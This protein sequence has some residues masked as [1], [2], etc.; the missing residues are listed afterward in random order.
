M[1]IGDKDKKT[2]V[3]KIV[4]QENVVGAEALFENWEKKRHPFLCRACRIEKGGYI[5][6]DFGREICG[7]VH[8]LFGWND[9]RGGVRIRL[10]ESV[11]ETCA[12][13]GEKNA[14][15]H[16]SL[17][18]AVYPVV[19][20]GD[21]STSESGFRFARIDGAKEEAVHV[22]MIFVEEEK[23]GLTPKGRFICSDERLNEI[24]KVAE[25]TISL[26]V[27]SD[28][29][30]DGIKRDRVFW[31]G[32]FYPELLGASAIYGQIPQFRKALDMV[33]EFQGSWINNIP[34]YSAW[35]LICLEKYYELSADDAYVIEM[36]PYI[37]KV[38]KDFSIIVGERGDVSYDKSELSYY[39]GNE[40]FIDW[41]TYST[42][43]SEIGWK[44]L[45]IYA[46]KQT[47]ILLTRFGLS[48]ARADELLKRLDN[49]EYKASKFKQ[50]TAL[51][52]LAGKIGEKEARS[53][54]ECDGAA[55]M[56]AF[57]SFAIAE[58]LRKIGDGEFVLQILKEYFGA[59][60][61]LGATTFW[62]D[63]DLKWL[64]DN[65]LPLDA[66]PEEGRKSIHADFGR[67]CYTGLR[68][69]LCHG[70]SSGF[71]DFFYRHILGIMAVE[72]GY[73]KIKIEPHLCGMDYAEGEI[74][75]LYG[76]IYI[77]H[78]VVN[79]K[80]ESTVRLPEGITREE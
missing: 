60:L 70:W 38:I 42:E 33:K 54:L 16:H 10:G 50:V 58:A 77:R 41:P 31:M 44:Y 65:P 20:C 43:D 1:N 21:V 69:S 39:V 72:P 25:H 22:S 71:I 34:S 26:C 37:E 64:E 15:N 24:Y 73:K 66:M 14:G 13:M 59:M 78:E 47:K 80:V 51:G 62:E 55:G 5:I 11:V 40:F 19:S 75:S 4:K 12:E 29:V 9:I 56:T 49:Q 61:D 46:L 45:L 48:T 53:L 18:D 27:R 30:W 63:F 35:W 74:P 3:K 2:N 79:G 23:N 67:F 68:H 6:V 32:D 28:N 52:V 7:R 8:I 76:K 36:I 17:R 57:M